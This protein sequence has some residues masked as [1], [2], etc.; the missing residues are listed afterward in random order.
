YA[1]DP[2]TQGSGLQRPRRNGRAL[3]RVRLERHVPRS[4]GM[5]VG[6]HGALNDV[7]RPVVER[8]RELIHE[9]VPAC[10]EHFKWKKPV[11]G[12]GGGF[13]YLQAN[14]AHVNL[15]FNK[16]AELSDPEGVLEGTGKG[17]RHVKIRSIADI[18]E[19]TLVPLIKAVARLG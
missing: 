13:A 2:A 1:P 7:Q 18:S 10:P 9:S 15:G 19:D 3:R 14:K 5:E 11:F 17:M 16:G 6:I 12:Q 4:G 8:L